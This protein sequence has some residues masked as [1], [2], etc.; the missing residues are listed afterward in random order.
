MRTTIKWAT[1]LARYVITVAIFG[2]A[3]LFF[4]SSA[5]AH[6]PPSMSI[7]ASLYYGSFISVEGPDEGELR[8]QYAAGGDFEEALWC[9]TGWFSPG[10]ALGLQW[11]APATM[12]AGFGAE[13]CDSITIGSHA[14][15][16]KYRDGSL[17][18]SDWSASSSFE[19][20]GY[21]E[22]P[23]LTF[24][25]SAYAGTVVEIEGPA[26][27]AGEFRLQYSDNEDFASSIVCDTGWLDSGVAPN[28]VWDLP[29]TMDPLYDPYAC[30]DL[31]IG[32]YAVRAQFRPAGTYEESMWTEPIIFDYSEFVPHED[33]FDEDANIQGSGIPVF[34]GWYTNSDVSGIN[35]RGT[36]ATLKLKY[37]YIGNPNSNCASTHRVVLE[38]HP[39]GPSGPEGLIQA[40][41]IRSRLCSDCGI[42]SNTES[43]IEWKPVGGSFVCDL[44]ASHTV[45]Q[46]KK[47]AVLKY[48]D[49]GTCQGCYVARINGSQIG[50]IHT[51]GTAT[52]GFD[53]ADFAGA[54]SE[55]GTSFSTA[56]GQISR[57]R[58][59]KKASE[60]TP[61]QRTSQAY[62]CGQT[63]TTISA[64]DECRN[65]DDHY[66]FAKP[67]NHNNGWFVRRW[68][69]N[70]APND[71]SC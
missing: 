57:V 31:V 55:Y 68:V 6:D 7:P 45:D 51:L 70:G 60:D 23:L 50:S 11:L 44:V 18:E 48:H 54:T 66:V 49:Q 2:P 4:P 14:V 38:R 8:L 25:D 13:E 21:Y 5:L 52:D 15:R 10:F 58:W 35:L 17:D 37:A 1:G 69:E 61:W 56:Q 47:Y 19:Y 20:E 46:A 30:D 43:F 33:D 9:D 24:P 40:G 42:S 71:D 16:A 26:S 27:T 53:K 63:W 62:C 28:I 22:E 29:E 12:E 41:I 3:F 67:Y 34:G 39:Q 65:S 64:P 59:G 36:R 32:T